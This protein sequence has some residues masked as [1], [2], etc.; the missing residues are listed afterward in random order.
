MRSIVSIA[1]A[2][3]FVLFI[4]GAS[5]VLAD[6]PTP[7]GMPEPGSMILAAPV[8][9]ETLEDAR[10][11]ADLAQKSQ[12]D[13]SAFVQAEG[14]TCYPAGGV[15]SVVLV[16][17]VEYRGGAVIVKIKAPTQQGEMELYAVYRVQAESLEKQ[18][19]AK[20]VDGDIQF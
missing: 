14:N 2:F 1:A 9:C 17:Y 3:M 6:V 13:A 20:P 11:F 4:G 19:D 16:A 8:A 7:K 18:S 5:G 12:D 10:K 15:F